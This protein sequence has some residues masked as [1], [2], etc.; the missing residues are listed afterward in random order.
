MDI[1]TIIL[2]T[3]LLPAVAALALSV[4]GC[5]D[6]LVPGS[7]KG[8][9]E[10]SLTGEALV[11]DVTMS[12]LGD[13]SSASSMLDHG[14]DWENYVD[15]SKFRVLFFD[16]EG[17]YIFEADPR[18]MT[19][20]SKDLAWSGSTDAYR[21]TIPRR[22]LKQNSVNDAPTEKIRDVIENEGFKVAVLANWPTAVEDVRGYDPETGDPI[23]GSET[24]STNLDF[25]YDETKTQEHSKL[26]YL[27]HCIY[28][29]VYGAIEGG[30]LK[31]PA[32]RHLVDYN[33]GYKLGGR[34]GVYSNWV[35]YLYKNQQD[36]ADFIR[37]GEDYDGDELEGDVTF[38]FSCSKESGDDFTFTPYSY[39]RKL[40]EDNAYELDNIWRLWNFSGGETCPYNAKCGTKVN[41]KGW[42]TR[43]YW[44][45]RNEQAL[46]YQLEKQ[47]APA[48]DG[49]YIFSTGFDIASLKTD[50]VA[51]LRYVPVNPD[52]VPQEGEANTSGY[53]ELPNAIDATIDMGE[54][55]GNL[56][57]KTN[58]A[59]MDEFKSHAL[60]L[61]AYGEGTLRIRC[62]SKDD[63]KSTRL[64]VVTKIPGR[65]DSEKTA[66]FSYRDGNGMSQTSKEFRFYPADNTERHQAILQN[67]PFQETMEYAQSVEYILEPQSNPYLE[68]YIGSIGGNID[69]YEI[70]YMR[71]RHIYDSA[72]NCIMPSADHPI[73]MY[74]LQIFDPIGDYLVDN[75]TFNMS[76][77]SANSYLQNL[78]DKNNNPLP[79]YNYRNVYLLRSVAKVELRFARSVFSKFPPEHVMMRVMNRTARC[80]PKDVINPT[81]WIWYGYDP[82]PEDFPETSKFPD[83]WQLITQDVLKNKFVGAVAEFDNICKYGPNYQS[84]ANTTHAYLT[85]TS[86]FYGAWIDGAGLEIPDENGNNIVNRFFW[87]TPWNWGIDNPGQQNDPELANIEVPN[88]YPY[89]RIFNS[90]VDR[91]DFCR[92]HKL[93][94]TDPNYIRYAMYVPEKNIDDADNIGQ[95]TARPK[96][97][98]VEIR[99]KG[100]NTAL[101]YDDDDCY[102]VYFTNYATNNGIKGVARYGDSNWDQWEQKRENLVNLQP[103][104]RNCHYIFTITSINDSQLGVNFTVCGAASRTGKTVVFK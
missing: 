86:W 24:L 7:E 52:F 76:D 37:K 56:K 33:D 75:E 104:M 74:G 5:V 50:N 100:V 13:D 26:E 85:R 78:T 70:E 11:F 22:D 73:P 2:K 82:Q 4:T 9:L 98:H 83:T 42:S 99:F 53:L 27:S 89:P 12:K 66:F 49:S 94:D 54:V 30:T 15:P 95:L 93:P 16:L 46:I 34:M 8:K 88:D 63:V 51:G 20:V 79:E 44:K 31:Y 39:T 102:R 21:I 92:F 29:N 103:V 10:G 40:D 47:G 101:N 60:Y 43:T 17:N 23:L 57:D 3:S 80:E 81:E 91:S 65:D 69:I 45:R 14:E 64:V 48:E 62:K 84:G 59:R 1:K 68:V 25:A 18:Y 96:V 97:E 90:R 71:A 67:E 58:R 87:Q 72:R 38:T 19:I 61:P 32:Y 6:E 77:R 41:T 28:D 55:A 36:A 35:S